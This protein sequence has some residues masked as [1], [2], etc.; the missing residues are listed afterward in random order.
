MGEEINIVEF[1]KIATPEQKAVLNTLYELANKEHDIAERIT[2]IVIAAKRD[3][4]VN[5]GGAIT[6][7]ESEYD[8]VV[9]TM[10]LRNAG[11]DVRIQISDLLKKAVN[12]LDMG[13]VGI[14][15]RQYKNYVKD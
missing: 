14:I 1:L 7:I 13:N 9:V 4:V 12:E 3:G 15:R 11:S 6:P 8:F 2:N 10:S 5:I